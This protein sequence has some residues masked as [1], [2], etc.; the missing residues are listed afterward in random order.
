MNLININTSLL[1]DNIHDK[2]L[3]IKSFRINLVQSNTHVFVRHR[4]WNILSLKEA[5]KIKEK[6]PILNFSLTAS[7]ELQLF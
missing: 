7:K 4:N 2:T 6:K 5:I 3:G 1:N